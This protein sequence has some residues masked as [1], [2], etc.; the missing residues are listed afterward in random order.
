VTKPAIFAVDDDRNS[1]AA[2]RDALLR[3]YREDYV[4]TTPTSAEDALRRLVELRVAEAPVALVITPL[5]PDDQGVEVLSKARG[6][7]PNAK[8][9]LL[10]PRGDPAGPS[11]RVPTALLQDHALAEPILRAM[12]M[13]LSDSYLP[14]PASPGDESFHRGVSEL[15]EE[16]AHSDSPNMPA[17]HIIG[18]VR[19]GRTHQ[20][21][22]LLGRNSIPY[23]F[24]EA[25][26]PDG[27]SWLH[28]ATPGATVLPV[29]VLYN[30][31]TL[32]DPTNE[33]IAAAFGL[34]ALPT[35]VVDVA[36][37]G[38][39]PAGLSTAVYTASEGLTTLLLEREAIGGQAGSSSLIRNYLG[40]P[41][42]ISG[43]NLATRAFEQAWRFGAI[44]SVAGPVTGF[45]PSAAGYSLD[46]GNGA[47]VQA[48]AVVIATGVSY[49]RLSAPGLDRLTGAGVFY[50]AIAS[51]SSSLPG[52]H[53]FIAGAA[54][55]AGQAAINLARHARQVTILA[56][57]DSLALHMSQYLIDEIAATANID[58]RT[59]TEVTG[60]EG[61]AALKSLILTHNKTGVNETVEAS[62]L[63]VLIGA[64]PHTDW[65]PPTVTRDHNGFIITGDDLTH[66]AQTGHGR[67][68][69]HSPLPLETN[70][71]GVFAAGDVRAGSVKR[72]ASAVG[73][74]SIVGS[75]VSRY[76]Q[77]H[78]R[79]SGETPRS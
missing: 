31:E 18:R 27:E 6:L 64:A 49:R 58:V 74:G 63:I 44:T 70:M 51:E 9:V 46:I 5:M 39:G 79:A 26:T 59:N 48:R 4:I 76:L 29:L 41:R 38:A 50:G 20:L 3:R 24:H 7:H 2:V 32:A 42:G 14:T 1:L 60:A 54:N 15:L 19:S 16:W 35:D 71:P 8:R 43:A 23:Q 67:Q 17:V 62:A 12:A 36:I 25:D 56:R 33:Q 45:A 52:Q 28:Q 77:E 55:S 73:E 57:G 13:G 68:P 66:G 10:V 75:L 11:L 69:R 40:F 72:V 37:I 53:V 65:L 61:E 78:S 47:H 34:A 22:D 21:R 30:G